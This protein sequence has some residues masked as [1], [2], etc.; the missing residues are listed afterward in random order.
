MTRTIVIIIV[1]DII[2]VPVRA[3]VGV[4]ISRSAYKSNMSVILE[5]TGRHNWTED[6]IK[7]L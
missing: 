4:D 1:R 7:A 3:E 5:S 6:V 2:R